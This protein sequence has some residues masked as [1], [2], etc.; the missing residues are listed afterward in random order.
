MMADG[1]GDN[2]RRSVRRPGL[3]RARNM[4]VEGG[5]SGWAGHGWLRLRW[6]KTPGMADQAARRRAGVT[7]ATC[8]VSAAKRRVPLP[9]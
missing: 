7:R 5:T 6:P 2:G 9:W 4:R 3:A 1:P 8:A